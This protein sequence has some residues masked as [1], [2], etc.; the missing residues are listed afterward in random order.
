[1]QRNHLKTHLQSIP[2]WPGVYQMK[3]T[4]GKIIYVG[5]ANNL[6][7]RLRS[8]FGYLTK[9]EPR[10]RQMVS[11]IADFEFT[12]T[13]SETEALILENTFIKLFQ[14]YYN[15][16]LKDDKNYPYIKINL[17]EDF[18]QIEFTRK[19]LKD[20][21]RY[22]G[23]F[24][25]A[26]AL[27]KTL[28]LLKRL[29]PYRSCTKTITGKD[30]RP[31]LEYY[32]NRC[33]APCVGLSTIDQYHQVINQV[34][35]FL[36]GKTGQVTNELKKRMEQASHAL[37]F[38]QA[39]RLRDQLRAIELVSEEQKVTVD[40]R[41]DQDVIAIAPFN[42]NCW[43][44]LFKIRNT[45]LVA[46][47]HFLMEG[48]RYSS[49]GEILSQ[50]VKQFYDSAMFIPPLLLLQHELT[51]TNV[52]SE[53][54]TSKKGVKVNIK[55]PKR[56]EKQRLVALAEVNAKQGVQQ[57]KLKWLAN[58]NILD[59]ALEDLSENLN[60]VDKPHRIEC[61]D[62]S[63]SSGTNP[64]GSMVV[65]QDGEPKTSHYRRFRIKN[66]EG[67]N[68]YAMMQ[69]MLSR[70]FKRLGQVVNESQ[71][72][73]KASKN[74]SWVN[75]P[76]LIIIDGGKGHLSAALEVLLDLGV[77]FIPI[78]A[79]A[80]ENEELFVPQSPDPV[81]LPRGSS[82]LF[83]VQRIRDE[84]HRFAITFHRQIR[85]KSSVESAID[86]V[87]GIGPKRKRT[88]LRQFG[89]IRGLSTANLEEIAAAP[90]MTL[91]LAKKVKQYIGYS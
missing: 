59:Q 61:Y 26:G 53:W 32:I 2:P 29:F 56:G 6:Q 11:K 51:D 22:F 46:Q 13:D 62:I 69:E 33:V 88:L 67:I 55:I 39:A 28:S 35:F 64:V 68:D 7:N 49:Y 44:E 66:V 30:A 48:A 17:T 75:T 65:F 8:Y 31:C 89:S 73:N 20:G 9:L 18:P 16:R 60:L 72:Q 40:G 74:D 58:K 12:V 10:I 91:S 21:A 34:I 76:D 80:K 54:L 42:D 41:E 81:I 36:E 78:A 45:K 79:L 71:S 38:E 14:P 5:K 24:A 15:V 83:L 52:V 70:R 82:S 4:Q 27:R 63:N 90:G 3:N 86:H 57:Y 25:S 1:M 19:V 85:S 23:P 50:F 84:A 77:N 37:E 87:P 43:V 47:D